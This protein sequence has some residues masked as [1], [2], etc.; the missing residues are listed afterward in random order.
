MLSKKNNPEIYVRTGYKN[1]D[2][3][4]LFLLPIKHSPNYS[5]WIFTTPERAQPAKSPIKHPKASM[6]KL[7]NGNTWESN[8]AA[9]AFSCDPTDQLAGYLS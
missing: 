7:S 1:I 9:S 3:N 4:S 2:K 8:Y 6:G 5:S